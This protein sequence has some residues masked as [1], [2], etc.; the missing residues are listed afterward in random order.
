MDFAPIPPTSLLETYLISRKTWFALAQI[1][2][3]AYE[4]FYGSKPDDVTLI[5]DNGAYEGGL[6]INRYADRIFDYRPTVA[7]LPD[8]LLGDADRNLHLGLGFLEQC[9]PA[10]VE[11][12]FVPQARPGDVEGFTRT[13]Y[14]ALRDKRITWLGIP[15]CLV[16]DISDNPLARVH[17]AAAV[18]RDYPDIKI[19]ALGMINGCVPEL[20]YLQKAGVRSCDSSWPF[21][22]GDPD[23][24]LK[25]IDKCLSTP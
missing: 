21:N 16:T 11:W 9:S 23:T 13:A 1:D 15:R 12:M 4:S 14:I 3:N 25:E 20:Y 24:N 5:L 18:K 10:G 17:F 22:H 7:V 6:V 8:L 19:H 2:E